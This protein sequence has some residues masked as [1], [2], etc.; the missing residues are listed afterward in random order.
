[1]ST[2]R[3]S[4]VT[5]SWTTDGSVNLYFA[6]NAPAGQKRT[7]SRPFPA[8]VLTDDAVIQPREHLFDGTWKPPD[9]ELLK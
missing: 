6:P 9:I 2:A 3:G 5:A 8:K 1:M 7:G 4:S